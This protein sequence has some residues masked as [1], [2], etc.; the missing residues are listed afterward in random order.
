M[1]WGKSDCFCWLFR[2]TA[3]FHLKNTDRCAVFLGKRGHRWKGIWRQGQCMKDTLAN[4]HCFIFF[5][6]TVSTKL[7]QPYV[8]ELMGLCL[9]FAKERGKKA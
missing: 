8:K 4:A 2:N 3:L 5:K 7:G 6:H 9:T 1:G